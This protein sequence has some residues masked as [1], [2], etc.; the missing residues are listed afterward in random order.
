MLVASRCV[1]HASCN[2][3]MDLFYF[4]PRNANER[5]L[6]QEAPLYVSVC[7]ARVSENGSWMAFVDRRQITVNKQVIHRYM[8]TLGWLDGTTR[9]DL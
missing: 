6:D 7:A 1:S 3:V 9:I 2:V 8:G 4:F 5:R